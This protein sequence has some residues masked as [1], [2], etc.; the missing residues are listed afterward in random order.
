MG[1]LDHDATPSALLQV[2]LPRDL[3]CAS[4]AR[5]VVSDAVGDRLTER[6]LERALLATSELVTN[7]WKH[8]EGQIGLTV[9]C[10][11]QSL[12]IE[13]IDEG[14][15]AVPEIREQP[16]DENGGWGLRIVDEVALQWGCFEGTTHVWV[17]LPLS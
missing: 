8:G 9:S 4:T 15:G 3:S 12:R 6:A 14:S 13:V 5:R 10:S 16:A 11:A 2:A 7:A 1:N 17:E